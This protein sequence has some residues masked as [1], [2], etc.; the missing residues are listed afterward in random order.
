MITVNVRDSRCI[1]VQDDRTFGDVCIIWEHG[2]DDDCLIKIIKELLK[3]D[4]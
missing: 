1:R 4:D 2:T 3:N